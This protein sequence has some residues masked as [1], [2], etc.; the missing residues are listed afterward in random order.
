MKAAGITPMSC[1]RCRAAALMP[2]PLSDIADYAYVDAASCHVCQRY[3][4]ITNLPE[5][6][7]ATYAAAAVRR[8]R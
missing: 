6:V 3:A 8:R 7:A 1:R 5:D 4:S 2:L